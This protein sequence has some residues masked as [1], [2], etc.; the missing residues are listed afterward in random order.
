MLKENQN[1]LE[2]S[3]EDFLN[4]IRGMNKTCAVDDLEN[5]AVTFV[6]N[7]E[8]LVRLVD[9]I[10]GS[11][12]Q[13]ATM[14]ASSLQPLVD[15][16]EKNLK[17][18]IRPFYFHDVEM[19]FI[20]VHNHLSQSRPPKTNM[21]ATSAV[22][23]PTAL[24]GANAMRVVY[25]PASMDRPMKMLHMGNVV[26]GDGVDIGPHATI[27]RASLGSTVIGD[28]NHIGSYVNIGHNVKTGKYCAFTPYVCVGG[29]THIADNVVVGMGSIIRDNI[30][31]CSDV[32]IGQ[33]SNVVKTIDEPGVYYGSPAIRQGEWDGRW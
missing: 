18:Q 9:G 33:G 10:R 21:I 6:K 26:I 7:G 27:H 16:L 3:F 28:Y 17:A 15:D 25:D 24:I 13:I 14:C 12:K 8:W 11:R 29:S 30:R 19:K 4:I 5:M 32:R 1:P 20:R 31:I 22:S 23:H 2:L